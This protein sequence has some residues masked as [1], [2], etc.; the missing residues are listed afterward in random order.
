MATTNR[1]EFKRLVLKIE[2]DLFAQGRLKALLLA[3]DTALAN[4]RQQLQAVKTRIKREI[5]TASGRKADRETAAHRSPCDDH[6][7]SN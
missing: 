5:A 3:V 2:R 7:S 1:A 6:A 4:D